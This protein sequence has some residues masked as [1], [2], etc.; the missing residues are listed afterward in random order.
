[1]GDKRLKRCESDRQLAGVCG[2]LANYLDVDPNVVRALAVFGAIFGGFPVIVIYAAGAMYLP[3]DRDGVAEIAPQTEF[4]WDGDSLRLT[5]SAPF[6][7]YT[8]KW[9]VWIGAWGLFGILAAFLSTIVAFV[10]FLFF[11][12][13]D[14]AAPLMVLS[15]MPWVAVALAAVAAAVGLTRRPYTLTCTHTALWVDLPFR[16]PRRIDLADVESLK[17][18]GQGLDLRLRN[19]EVIFLPKPDAER[20][21]TLLE[22]VEQSRRRATSHECEVEEGSE[23]RDEVRRMMA[24]QRKRQTN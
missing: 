2:G 8:V 13:G 17:D 19:G 5:Y 10:A 16:K 4:Q 7:P 11:G 12:D 23:Q 9:P 3:E 21:E 18:G 6:V 15:A 24:Q 22:V 1:M 14:L 20:L